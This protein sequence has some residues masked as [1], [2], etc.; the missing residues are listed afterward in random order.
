MSRRDEREAHRGLL[1]RLSCDSLSLLKT[2]SGSID[3]AA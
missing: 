2:I 1:E 3:D